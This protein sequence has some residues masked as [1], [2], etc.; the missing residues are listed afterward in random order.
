M[1]PTEATGKPDMRQLR[2]STISANKRQKCSA[3]TAKN[4]QSKE[5]EGLRR[6]ESDEKH[7]TRDSKASKQLESK[8]G[9][10]FF[11]LLT[12]NIHKQIK[13]LTA[14]KLP[15]EPPKHYTKIQTKA[16]NFKNKNVSFFFF[17]LY[18]YLKEIKG[19]PEEGEWQEDQQQHQKPCL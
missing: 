13:K 1:R 15:K 6:T 7:K 17:N 10:T 19:V 3:F 11:L 16:Q 2:I 14:L 4:K 12:K 18:S 8:K 5:K 9:K